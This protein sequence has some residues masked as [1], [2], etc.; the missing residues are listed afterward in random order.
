[1]SIV[2]VLAVQFRV[3]RTE[4]AADA[5][6]A[7]AAEGTAIDALQA[8]FLQDHRLHHGRN[9]SAHFYH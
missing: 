5:K 4:F 3:F 8:G 2:I 6:S 1:M 7:A 9:L